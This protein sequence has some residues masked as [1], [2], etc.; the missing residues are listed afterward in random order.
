M[1]IIKEESYYHLIPEVNNKMS[2]DESLANFMDSFK[3]NYANFKKINL[4]LDFSNIINIDLNKIL[5]F[6]P[7]S[8]AHKSNNKSFVI[9]CSGIEFDQ[10]PDEIV[11]VPTLKEAEDIIEIEDIER[12]LGI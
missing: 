11:V 8:E 2:P 10:V 12:D 7:I 9:V 6:S 1:E 4:I 5:L 3:K